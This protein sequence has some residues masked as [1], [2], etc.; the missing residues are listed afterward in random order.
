MRTLDGHQLIEQLGI[1]YFKEGSSFGALSDE[2]IRYLI[3]KGNVLQLEKGEQVFAYGDP[4]DSF[5]IVL[6]GRIKFLKPRKRK[7]G[8]NHIRD[9]TFGQEFGCI[10]MIGLHER[11]G[12]NFAVEDSTIV[13]VSCGLFHALHEALPTD[14]GM[15]LLNLSRELAR[16]LRESD[17][18]LGEHDIHL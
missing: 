15:L 5:Y 8:Y 10:A 14:F 9:Y 11:V 16:R 3:E 7:S 6:K 17:S 13:Q 12:S 18:K 1:D 2:A 4:G